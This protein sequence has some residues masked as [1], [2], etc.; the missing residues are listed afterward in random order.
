MR[1]RTLGENLEVSALD[2][3]HRTGSRPPQKR[4]RRD[5]E[6]AGNLAGGLEPLAHPAVRSLR[7]P[8]FRLTTSVTC[9]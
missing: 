6:P 1:T 8:R 9:S 2:R 4:S 7:T 5:A 3:R